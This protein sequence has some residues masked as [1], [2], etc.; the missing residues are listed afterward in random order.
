MILLIAFAWVVHGLATLNALLGK[1]RSNPHLVVGLL[2]FAVFFGG[3]LAAGAS[4]RWL[5]F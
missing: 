3:P 5:S 1:P 2:M 4:P